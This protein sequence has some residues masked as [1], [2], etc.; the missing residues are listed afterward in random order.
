MWFAGSPIFVNRARDFAFSDERLKWQ[1]AGAK[2][3][4]LDETQRV[5]IESVV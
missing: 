3:W 1:C 5:H 2:T 4:V